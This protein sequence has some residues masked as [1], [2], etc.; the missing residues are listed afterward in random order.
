[1]I[2]RILGK[3]KGEYV[4]FAE[5]KQYISCVNIFKKYELWPYREKHGKGL[6]RFTLKKSEGKIFAEKFLEEG[7]EIKRSSLRG[8]PCL[9]L[10]YRRRFVA[11]FVAAFFFLSKFFS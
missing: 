2:S 4:F 6:F 1:M 11:M 3:I 5:E 7:L 9:F 8:I 10:R